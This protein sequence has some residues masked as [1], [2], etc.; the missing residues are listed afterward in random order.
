MGA[1]HLGADARALEKAA[2]SDVD[3]L[4]FGLEDA[5]APAAKEEARERVCGAAGAGAY[6]SRTVAIRT[7][8]IATEWHG[9]DVRAAA[10]RPGRR[11]SWSRRSAPV[12]RC[13][14]PG[15]RS[16]P[17][18]ARRGSDLGRARDADR[19]AARARERLL[20][21]APRLGL[22]RRSP[23]LVSARSRPAP[24]SR[25]GR[26]RQLVGHGSDRR[27]CAAGAIRRATPL[28]RSGSAAAA[29]P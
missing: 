8:G 9:D 10:P 29:W 25:A 28:V 12:R 22:R 26:R 19:S 2:A 24:P 11:G 15:A 16:K 18:A 21:H 7:D 23:A 13:L 4:I 20:T 27:G 6:G 14:R 3:A 5:A 1:V 17:P